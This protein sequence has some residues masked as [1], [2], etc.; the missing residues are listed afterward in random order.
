MRSKTNAAEDRSP[1][2]TPTALWRV[3]EV[4]ALPD[5][6]LQVRFMGDTE[7]L[8]DMS[9]LILSEDAGVFASLCDAALFAQYI[10]NLGP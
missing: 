10:S 2:V 6:Q 4:I 3:A 7:G 8:I 9:R 5:Y 1:G